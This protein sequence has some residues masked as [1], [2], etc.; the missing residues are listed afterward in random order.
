MIEI[1]NIDRILMAMRNIFYCTF[2]RR[3]C[4]LT[5]TIRKV[6]MSSQ[7]IKTPTIYLIFCW[8]TCIPKI[9]IS[10]NTTRNTARVL[11]IYTFNFAVAE[12]K[13]S[14]IADKP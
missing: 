11:V 10:Q 7:G 5:A 4:M 12:K 6:N 3:S 2:L 14:T 13:F 9:P 1:D 8:E